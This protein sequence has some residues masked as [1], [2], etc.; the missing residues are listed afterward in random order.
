VSD[1]VQCSSQL[2]QRISPILTISI[3]LVLTS[4]KL[5]SVSFGITGQISTFL[6]SEVK[7][8]NVAEKMIANLL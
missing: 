8:F 3:H 4:P 7:S 1:A 6:A 5:I 2:L